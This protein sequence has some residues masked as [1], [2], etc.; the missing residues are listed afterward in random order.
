MGGDWVMPTKEQYDELIIY[1]NHT[2]IE[3]YQNSG[4]NGTLLTSKI[5]NTK[6]LFMPVS[7]YANN[8]TITHISDNYCFLLTNSITTDIIFVNAYGFH[9][10]GTPYPSTGYARSRGI[11]VRGVI[12]Y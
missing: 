5:D 1:T 6:T 11:C 12:N 7:G 8:G 10:S 9:T 4:I 2:F 3:N